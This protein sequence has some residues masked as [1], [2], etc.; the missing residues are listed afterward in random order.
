MNTWY[1]TFNYDALGK[2]ELALYEG[3]LGAY[4]V[5]AHTGTVDVDGDCV[6]CIKPGV[7]YLK[8]RTVFLN[9]N[10]GKIY[11][12][13]LLTPKHRWSNEY[14]LTTWGGGYEGKASIRTDIEHNT[15]EGLFG[16]IDKILEKQAEI[17][18]YINTPVSVE[19][20]NGKS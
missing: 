17:Q 1:L 11:R 6:N 4:Y 2:G 8:D 7:W 5:G 10:R 3:N 13:H 9:G 15:C 12:V 14:F 16:R 20:K 19:V 18:L